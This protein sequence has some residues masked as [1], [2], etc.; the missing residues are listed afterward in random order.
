MGTTGSA[1]TS[2]TRCIINSSRCILCCS[3]LMALRVDAQPVSECVDPAQG[4]S[5]GAT[6]QLLSQ[7]LLLVQKLVET[8]SRPVPDADALR[9]RAE[10]AWIAGRC[11]EADGYVADALEAMRQ[12]RRDMDTPQKRHA[13]LKRDVAVLLDTAKSYVDVLDRIA[14]ERETDSKTAA[15]ARALSGELADAQALAGGEDLVRAKVALTLLNQRLEL[16]L[17]DARQNETLVHELDLS[18]PE[19]AYD[20]E[21]KTNL[22]YVMLLDLLSGEGRLPDSAKAYVQRVVE[23]NEGARKEAES[24]AGYG[25]HARAAAKLE[26]ASK[27]LVQGLRIAG[28]PVQ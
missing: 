11:S 19:V 7:K 25:D 6:H 15:D 22:S 16:A 14:G 26:A 27:K 5:P 1:G 18:N 9:A 28:V 4:E 23:Q 2:C 12:A 3:L 21:L 10:E 24:L 20:Y 17:V 13:R 8:S